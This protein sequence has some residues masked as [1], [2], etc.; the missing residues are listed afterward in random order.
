MK[1]KVRR[2]DAGKE[3]N[4]DLSKITS[5]GAES[6]EA[7]QLFVE[8]MQWMEEVFEGKINGKL[9]CPG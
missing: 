6:R 2:S 4:K 9:Y 7:T 8:P 5:W 3:L 1:M